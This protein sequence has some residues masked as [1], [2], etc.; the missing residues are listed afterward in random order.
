M[1]QTAIADASRAPGTK[2]ASSH[3]L[4]RA[5]V[6][7][8]PLN[9]LA[10]ILNGSSRVQEMVQL[11][12]KLNGNPQEQEPA[13]PK[14]LRV[15]SSAE[16]RSVEPETSTAIPT[17]QLMKTAR[18]EED[19]KIYS[20]SDTDN[21]ATGMT[22]PNH[23]LYLR[24]AGRIEA[25]N[26]A[27]AA[28]PL[29]AYAG[30]ARDL[31]GRSYTAVE[32]RFKRNLGPDGVNL[33]AAYESQVKPG[34]EA[35]RGGL[36][37]Q[38][39]DVLPGGKDSTVASRVDVAGISRE[40]RGAT[41]A[42]ELFKK[43]VQTTLANRT[44]VVDLAPVRTLVRGM[45]ATIY[46]RE[47]TKSTTTDMLAEILHL[48][49]D[50]ARNG[51]PADRLIL[52]TVAQIREHAIG[53]VAE[54]PADA[55]LDLISFHR[56]NFQ[57]EALN[58][59][60]RADSNVLLYRAC[61]VMAS[62]VLGNE[63]TPERAQQLKVYEAGVGAFHYAAK[64]L[65]E[66]GDWVSLESFAASE[67]D[68]SITGVTDFRNLD[69][70]WQYVMYGS[71]AGPADGPSAEDR[72][73]EAYT[74]L[75]YL[76]KGIE[77]P[78]RFRSRAAEKLTS[79]PVNAVA[80]FHLFPAPTGM[81]ARF[82][83]TK[84]KQADA[85]LA[86]LKDANVILPTGVVN[87]RV[88]EIADLT[89]YLKAEYRPKA[90]TI[91][92]I[93]LE[94]IPEAA[95]IQASAS[96]DAA[97][98]AAWKELTGSSEEAAESFL[99]SATSSV[100][101]GERASKVSREAWIS[102]G[103]ELTSGGGRSDAPGPAPIESPPLVPV[104]SESVSL[105]ASPLDASS[106]PVSIHLPS[107]LATLASS[108]GSSASHGGDL[109]GARP[110]PARSRREVINSGLVALDHLRDQWRR[111]SPDRASKNPTHYQ[112]HADNIESITRAPSHI[113]LGQLEDD[114]QTWLDQARSDWL[115]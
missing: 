107:T 68:R 38:A 86:Q 80:F 101:A 113:P 32:L 26:A 111:A 52:E 55:A 56:R 98:V 4:Q 5:A 53:L 18:A 8:G 6:S 28:S 104:L 74:R 61:D 7:S 64:I 1:K 69:Q 25:I 21:V 67:R 14:D 89:N 37:Q 112:I 50:P 13:Q 70:T 72:F 57:V 31:F 16:E 11:A 109:S 92:S 91:R 39:E 77:E 19:G 58:T 20:V 49:D 35:F 110:A 42:V 60:R 24:E 40:L 99:A 65:T 79:R 29:E 88:R 75:R 100:F 10:G 76:L 33:Q 102:I 12:A 27:M 94:H 73:F 47:A 87:P 34:I 17:V 45:E 95:Y 2:P 23:E 36:Q 66:G 46:A 63:L 71:L 3:P 15:E 114:V 22:T 43:L 90:K 85:L 78:G 30:A 93:L 83:A 62:T 97:N 51:I 115:A 9:Q 48:L 81:F 54:L 106:S 84:E 105:A 96:S 103:K 41:A 44:D 82:S 59:V 108:P